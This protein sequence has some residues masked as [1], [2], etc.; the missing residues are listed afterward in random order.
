MWSGYNSIPM[1]EEDEQP[2]HGIN[3]INCLVNAAR[4]EQT[5]K[6]VLEQN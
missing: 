6:M 2:K 5:N 3:K 4:V 1:K